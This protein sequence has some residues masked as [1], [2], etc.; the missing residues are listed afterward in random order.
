MSKL[1]LENCSVLFPREERME[2]LDVGISDGKITQVGSVS[3]LDGETRKIDL[4]GAYLAPGFIDLQVNGGNGV[5]FLTCGAEDVQ[6]SDA[7]WLEHGTTSYLGT[8]I[9]QEPESMNRAIRTLSRA[10]ASALLGIHVEGPFLSREKRGTHN[11]KHLKKP[12]HD[13][14]EQIVGVC[15]AELSLFTF[16]PELEGAGELLDWIESIGATPSIGHS[17]ASYDTVG[18][19]LE[20]GVDSFTHLFNGMKGFHHRNPGTVGAAL[21][22]E[23]SVGLIADGLH[24]H[25]AAVRLV[26]KVKGPDHL[27][28]VTDAI[29][30]AGMADGEYVLGDQQ[31]I[32]EA[33]LARLEDGTIAGSTLTMETA[34]E[35]FI[36]FT[37]V[38]LTRAIKAVTI[39]PARLLQADGEIGSMEKGTRADLVVFDEEFNI[40]YTIVRGE[41]VFESGDKDQK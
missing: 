26:D 33:G 38:N 9:T 16:A 15:K 8:V 24:L 22:S 11:P 32:V 31:I 7:F 30:A 18:E 35:N 41:V 13:T 23:A 2:K 4:N 17:N 12:C 20:R 21:D 39:N 5:D 1:I 36:E 40:N 10:E 34:L 29:A 27:Y 28:L 14:F 37:G 3:G 25:P 6:R 19:F